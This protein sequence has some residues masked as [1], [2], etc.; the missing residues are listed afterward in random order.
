MIKGTK[1]GEGTFGI[2]YSGTCPE[3]KGRYAIKR[4]LIEDKTSFIGVL[5]EVDVLNKLRHHPHLVRLEQVAFGQPFSAECFS[6]LDGKDRISQRDDSMHFVFK[7][8]AYDLNTFIYG[9]LIIDFR[10]IKRYMVNILLGI[11]YMHSQ[12]IIHRDLKPSNILI[13]GEEKDAM[14]VGNVAKICDFGLSKPYTYQGYQTPNTVTSWYRAPEITLGYHH[15]D[16]KVDVWSVGCI[17]YEMIAK[18]A[19]IFDV[20]DNNDEIL[21]CI[22][23]ALPQ[24]LPMRKF[25]ELVRSNKWREIK[26]TPVHS[27]HIRRNFVQQIGLTN[28]GLEKFE[29]QIGKLNIFCDLLDNMLRF[30]WDDRYTATQCLDHPFFDEYTGIIG[31]TRKQFQPQMYK[32]QPLVI[33]KCVERKWMAQIATEIFNNRNN[34][35]WYSNRALFQAMDLFDRYLSVM[36]CST[37][38]PPNAMESDLKGFIHDKFGSKLRFM[39]CL[40]LCIKYFSSI[41]YPVSYDSIVDREYRTDDSKLIAEQFEGGF[42]KNC[43]EYNIYRSTVYE[44]ADNFNDK[45]E[46]IDIR[47]LIILYSM[48]DS[49]SGMTPSELYLYYRT[50]FRGYSLELLFSPIVKKEHIVTKTIPFPITNRST[51][52]ENIA[53]QN[54]TNNTQET[55]PRIFNNEM[56]QR[57]VSK[58]PN[59]SRFKESKIFPVERTLSS[60][61]RIGTSA[62]LPKRKINKSTSFPISTRAP[63]CIASNNFPKLSSQK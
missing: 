41:H 20:S 24:E 55:K 34:L 7:Q 36:F 54:N 8:A 42:I 63:M 18:R 45:L 19:F 22:L 12:K 16:Y 23:G 35:S 1:L 25:R 26:L 53:P 17:L 3:T 52:H 5:R 31:E 39:T 14:G 40:Y 2:V 37:I 46:D 61:P 58:A 28:E 50:N 38:I 56:Q 44:A 6:P 9:A 30:E 10:L 51:M 11:E 27:P 29:T 62:P 32:E 60:L 57:D 48:N 15:Y 47:D 49:F 59:H 21:S 33:H 13:F 4:N 43:L